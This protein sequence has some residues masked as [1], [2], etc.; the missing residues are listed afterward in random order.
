MSQLL[1]RYRR[2]IIVILV[3]VIFLTGAAVLG[4]RN[5]AKPRVQVTS[6]QQAKTTATAVINQDYQFQAVNAQ[7]QTQPI[8]YTIIQVDRKDEIKVKD[9]P[10]RAVANKDFLLVRLELTNDHPERLA[11]AS[12]DRVRLESEPGKLFA[13]DYHN[14][15]VVIDPLSTRR[16]V[17][18]FVVDTDIKNFVFLVGELE[19]DK[20]RLEVNF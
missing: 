18:A 14:G 4:K 6:E 16:D 20:Q 2:F 5:A 10:R 3:I 17:L 15:N 8:T 9:Q 13:P 11:I 7:K 19:G 12:A 1:R